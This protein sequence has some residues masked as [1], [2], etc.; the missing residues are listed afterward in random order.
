MK[1][2]KKIEL[3]TDKLNERLNRLFE[4]NNEYRTGKR[5]LEDWEHE[6]N[7]TIWA[8]REAKLEL[9]HHEAWLAKIAKE[10]EILRANS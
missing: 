8:I 3:L 2:K 4:V 5:C 1:I 7:K 10:G 6:S 9:K